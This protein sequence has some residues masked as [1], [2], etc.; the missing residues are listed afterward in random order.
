MG[1]RRL[2]RERKAE[3]QDVGYDAFFSD[4]ETEQGGGS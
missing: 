4:D 3:G 2:E 1:W